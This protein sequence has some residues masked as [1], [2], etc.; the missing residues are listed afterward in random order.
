MPKSNP[1][2]ILLPLMDA[3]GAS[4][5][6]NNFNDPRFSP[7]VAKVETLPLDIIM[8]IPSID[9]L[10]AEQLTFAERVKDEIAKDPK[11]QGR[12]MEALFL[13]GG[14]HGFFERK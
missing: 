8:L 4:G 14:F 2:N 6:V 1:T 12:K 13:E 3:Y 5:R 9:I 7:S 11:Y 10:V